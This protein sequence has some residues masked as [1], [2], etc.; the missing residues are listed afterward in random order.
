MALIINNE[1]SVNNAKQYKYKVVNMY[2]LID[3]FKQIKTMSGEKKFQ[4]IF[5]Y[6]L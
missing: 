1:Y 2:W 4:N 6:C 5:S 3:I